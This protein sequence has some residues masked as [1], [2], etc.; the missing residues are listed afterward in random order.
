MLVSS[1]FTLLLTVVSAH[2]SA[3]CTIMSKSQPG[4]FSVMAG[5]YHGAG[6]TLGNSKAVMNRVGDPIFKGNF[7][8]PACSGG[9]SDRQAVSWLEGQIRSSCTR[10]FS[11]THLGQAKT[12]RYFPSDGALSCY[13]EPDT[14]TRSTDAGRNVIFLKP[15]ARGTAF[16][17]WESTTL[18][19]FHYAALFNQKAGMFAFGWE[20]VNVVLAQGGRRVPCNTISGGTRHYLNIDVSDGGAPCNMD[21]PLVSGVPTPSILACKGQPSGSLC[22][23]ACDK[24]SG[25][26]TQIGEIKCS[27]IVGSNPPAS[28]WVSTM[29]CTTSTLCKMPDSSFLSGINGV[30][31]DGCGYFTEA[32]TQCG[33]ACISGRGPKYGSKLKCNTPSGTTYGSWSWV[34][35]ADSCVATKAPTLTPRPT[36][37]PTTKRPTKLPTKA[38]TTTASPTKYPTLSPTTKGPTW[39][40]TRLPTQAPTIL[41]YTVTHT[42]PV[43]PAIDPFDQAKF[44][45]AK[46]EYAAAMGIPVSQVGGYFIFEPAGNGQAATLQLVFE[47]KVASLVD[48]E[49]IEMKTA[50]T[51]LASLGGS[52]LTFTAPTTRSGIPVTINVELQGADPN[53]Y[54]INGFSN[55]YCGLLGVHIT[56]CNVAPSV[57]NGALKFTI[58][59]TAADQNI[60]NA[61]NQRA[62]DIQD[63]GKLVAPTKRTL[64]PTRAPTPPTRAGHLP[65]PPTTAPPTPVPPKVV[66]VTSSLVKSTHKASFEIT[67]AG[68]ITGVFDSASFAAKYAAFLGLGPENIEVNA[69]P[70]NGKFKVYVNV[71]AKSAEGKSEATSKTT[72]EAFKTAITGFNIERAVSVVQF[73]PTKI[74]FTV[75]MNAGRFIFDND[76]F[77]LNYLRKFSGRLT[78]ADIAKFEISNTKNADGTYQVVISPKSTMTNALR[79][80][81]AQL[82]LTNRPL[83]ELIQKTPPDAYR[84]DGGPWTVQEAFSSQGKENEL[85]KEKAIAPG[86]EQA[87]YDGVV[88]VAES[89]TGASLKNFAIAMMTLM[90]VVFSLLSTFLVHQKDKGFSSAV[91][92][93]KPEGNASFMTEFVWTSVFSRVAS[94]PFTSK[95][96]MWTILVFM[97]S[98]VAGVAYS[99]LSTMRKCYQTNPECGNQGQPIPG[100]NMMLLVGLAVGAWLP[101]KVM[102]AVIRSSAPKPRKKRL[103]KFGFETDAD[104]P[105]PPS[106][107]KRNKPA[108]SA[109]A[110][111][112]PPADEMELVETVDLVEG[113]QELEPVE[114]VPPPPGPPPARPPGAKSPSLHTPV[115]DE[116]ALTDRPVSSS[117][118]A[119]MDD[120]DDDFEDFQRTSN[121]GKQLSHKFRYVAYVGGLVVCAMAIL[122][123]WMFMKFTVLLPGKDA[124]VYFGIMLIA[125]LILDMLVAFV[126]LKKK[127]K[128]VSDVQE[129][130]DDVP[131]RVGSRKTSIE[132]V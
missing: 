38:P 81:I 93:G 87:T 35:T 1:A 79:K 47:I 12:W 45:Q 127:A 82:I 7:V 19:C 26:V 106:A 129:E 5:T 131:S 53:T 90:W 57:V 51:S 28:R 59:T 103:N 94:S 21:P 70:V 31:G 113:V 52:T 64:F 122:Y 75:K 8:L 110:P 116:E 50:P 117:P 125:G 92:A 67:I 11:H 84:V 36:R 40:P 60:A 132:A 71:Y 108:R 30:N 17:C 24:T 44:D 115:H 80:E 74:I 112:P 77:L 109:P 10:T 25:V 119:W 56:Q 18:R 9:W 66:P 96:R 39:A 121:D 69:V 68:D 41:P 101:A 95:E 16:G 48:V 123:C 83:G 61:L 126:L 42:T 13:Y 22:N 105:R 128:P 14:S 73:S 85:V 43:S 29:K 4:F 78:S 23:V 6:E 46:A 86:K 111:P 55:W 72:A 98:A 89:P 99:F 118:K 20:G 63:Q 88:V 32:G 100:V 33:F 91:R 97:I 107:M 37:R 76:T 65:A 34:G 15:I 54:D 2:T 3:L 27:V 130:T 102:E 120:D 104:V 49:N 114:P 58:T 62:K 124:G